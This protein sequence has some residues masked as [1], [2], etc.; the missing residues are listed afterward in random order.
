[1]V[2]LSAL[3]E[4]ASPSLAF[5]DEIGVAKSSLVLCFAHV[6]VYFSEL[7]VQSKKQL[8]ICDF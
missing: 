1:M 4:G 3:I 8:V 2:N 7:N 6:M 5:S